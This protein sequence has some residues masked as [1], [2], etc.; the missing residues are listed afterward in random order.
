M[1]MIGSSCRRE[2]GIIYGK[3]EYARVIVT[4]IRFVE[5]ERVYLQLDLLL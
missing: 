4:Q 5:H 1:M 2:C 3:A